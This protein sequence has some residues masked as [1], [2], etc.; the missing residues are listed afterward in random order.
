MTARGRILFV[1]AVGAVLAGLVHLASILLVPPLADRD[2]RARIVAAAPGE[3][4]AVLARPTPEA[5]LL[6]FMDPAAVL[7]A[8]VFDLADGPMRIRAA[9]GEVFLSLSL[10]QAGG[11]VFYALTD[12][13]ANRGLIDILLLTQAQFDAVS[14]RD[15]EDEPVRELRIVAPNPEGFVVIRAVA[16]VPSQRPAAE[17][18]AARA[19]CAK[20]KI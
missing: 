1:A 16:A 20:E 5:S 17:T 2:A 14:A 9:A 15:D 7:A 11:G 4:F 18:L 12:R 10:H 3:R 8:C 13:S 19:T 6:P